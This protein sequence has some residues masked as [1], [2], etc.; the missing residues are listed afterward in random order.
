MVDYIEPKSSFFQKIIGALG[1][2][3]V[4][5]GVVL[6]GVYLYFAGVL[7]N[8]PA[9]ML[10]LKENLKLTDPAIRGTYEAPMEDGS[11]G[12]QIM[13]FEMTFSEEFSLLIFILFVFFS[14]LIC[15]AVLRIII[16]AGSSMVKASTTPKQ[17]IIREREVP[18]RSSASVSY[19]ASAKPEEEPLAAKA[20]SSYRRDRKL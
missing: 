5:G 12:V 20:S 4:L 13:N 8:S 3:L 15:V 16:G 14:I 17:V 11:E 7:L 19:E 9:K 6:F 1:L 2:L 10:I 18:V